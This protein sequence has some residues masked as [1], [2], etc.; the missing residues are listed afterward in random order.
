MNS[1]AGPYGAESKVVANFQSVQARTIL[2]GAFPLLKKGL[3]LTLSLLS[4][5]VNMTRER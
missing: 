2:I 5:D 4:I 3:P 1:L